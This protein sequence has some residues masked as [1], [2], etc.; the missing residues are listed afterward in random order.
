MDQRV[1]QQSKPRQVAS[2]ATGTVL[3]RKCVCGGRPGLTGECAECSKKRLQRAARTTELETQNSGGVPPIVHEV[4]RSPGQPLDPATRAFFE[5]R[6]G[7]DF[8]QVRV[9]TDAKARESAH[10]VN[11]LAYTSGRDVV[12]GA[13]QYAPYKAA[14]QRLLA[15]ELTHVVQQSVGAGIRRAEEAI[16]E[17]DLSLVRWSEFQAEDAAQRIAFEE[18]AGGVPLSLR[19]NVLQKAEQVGGRVTQPKGA[20]SSYKSITAD[21]DGKDFVM[22]GDGTEILRSAGQSGRSYA[23]RAADAKAC[24][25]SLDDSYMNNPRYVGIKENG[26]I[27]EGKYTFRRMD[28]MTF[29]IAEQAK[30]AL[31]G[32]GDYIAPSG[33]SLHGDWGAAR[34]P[35]RPVHI[36]PTKFCGNT[37]SRSGFYLHGGVMPGSSGCIDIGN[38][39]IRNVVG[40]LLG[41]TDPVYLTV[42]YTQPPPDMGFLDRAAGRFMYPPEKNPSLT[43]RLKSVFGGGDK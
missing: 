22:L 28:M 27:P 32:E 42:K 23:V 20:K 34:A 12:F 4:L 19:S 14:G 24:G 25:G 26:P 38:G 11:A 36:A 40:A 30:M 15:H 2:L 29:N 37:G 17:A 1:T 39:A 35:L 10:A 41:Y 9:H 5:P 8:S 16:L 13:G 7:H 3:Q 33:A 18:K 31:A 21:F 6:F 43:D